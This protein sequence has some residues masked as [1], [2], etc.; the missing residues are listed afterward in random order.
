MNHYACYHIFHVI[1]FCILSHFSVSVS[2]LGA[3]PTFKNQPKEWGESNRTEVLVQSGYHHHFR[4]GAPGD[5]LWGGRRCWGPH[6]L[7][8]L[9][10]EPVG[11]SEKVEWVSQ[12][13]WVQVSK[14]PLRDTS[15]EKLVGFRAFWLRQKSTCCQVEEMR[16]QLAFGG[17]NKKPSEC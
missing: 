9:H 3:P 12:W 2:A 1:T 11:T 17:E 6:L 10:Q 15:N 4:L 14:G 16:H 8:Q 13:T 7:V 5:A